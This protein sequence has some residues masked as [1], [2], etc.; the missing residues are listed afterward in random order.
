MKHDIDLT[1]YL[2][3]SLPQA[4]KDKINEHLKTCRQCRGHLD[5]LQNSIKIF[6]EILNEQPD[7][8][9]AL[10]KDNTVDEKI[11][12]KNIK[13]LPVAIKMLLAKKRL[14]VRERLT[15]S[16]QILKT[17]GK[18]T[19][20]DIVE[21]IESLASELLNSESETE[22]SYALKRD[23]T[24]P[25]QTEIELRHPTRYEKA[26]FCIQD[27]TIAIKKLGLKTKIQITKENK[28]VDGIEIKIEKSPND[29]II[30]KTD[31]DGIVVY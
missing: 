29:I 3:N 6:S 25:S 17:R 8:F 30:L 1:G 15:E 27:F 19:V 5:Q 4:E 18:E 14:S 28:P 23:T 10:A 20:H 9:E 24:M 31:D 26:E 7:F 22:I 2:D 21:E 12:F 11:D 16:L 13:S